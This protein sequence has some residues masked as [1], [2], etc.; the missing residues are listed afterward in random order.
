LTLYKDTSSE[1]E[2]SDEPSTLVEESDE[3]EPEETSEPNVP[4][5]PTPPPPPTAARKAAPRRKGRGSWRSSRR[6]SKKKKLPEITE[7]A[8]EEKKDEAEEEPSNNDDTMDDGDTTAKSSPVPNGDTSEIIQPE[9]KEEVTKNDLESVKS[10]PMEEEDTQVQPESNGP[11]K[12]EAKEIEGDNL[13]KGEEPQEAET[14]ASTPPTTASSQR[15]TVSQL[16]QKLS[17]ENK[18]EEEGPEEKK[19]QSDDLS[20]ELKVRADEEEKEVKPEENQVQPPPIQPEVSEK[21]PDIPDPERSSFDPFFFE[22]IVSSVEELQE[23]IERFQDTSSG[24]ARPRCEV[25]LRERLQSLLEEAQPLAADQQQANQKICQQ[26]WKEWERYK[27]LERKTAAVS[28]NGTG[29]AVCS[30]NP[31][32]TTTDSD[33]TQDSGRSDDSDD[34]GADNANDSSDD[35]T[36]DTDGVRHSKRLRKRRSYNIDGSTRSSSPGDEE[37]QPPSKQNRKTSYNYDPGW[38][39]DPSTKEPLPGSSRR[40]R[41]F[42]PEMKNP[43]YWIGRRKTRATAAF[44]GDDDNSMEFAQETRQPEEPRHDDST[45]T[46]QSLPST[47][48]MSPNSSQSSDPLVDQLRQLRRQQALL[49]SNDLP[50]ATGAPSGTTISNGSSPAVFFPSKDTQGKL[51][52]VRISNPKATDFLTKVSNQPPS[53]PKVAGSDGRLPK[54]IVISQQPQ[55]PL[56]RPMG[57][58][59]QAP[60]SIDIT[61]FVSSY[62]NIFSASFKTN[63]SLFF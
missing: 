22:L 32:L 28:A 25:K 14:G 17:T 29:N 60:F 62:S 53:T 2:D 63:Y 40:Q 41:T 16:L 26:L 15:F 3:N 5:D 44:A 19:S 31:Y 7:E 9:V 56:Q 20:E 37:M 1:S 52:S 33:H 11:V 21:V 13:V 43:E 12:E 30:T 23:W 10:E 55:P 24:R 42:D 48:Q 61:N 34:S 59:V 35:G 36:A 6:R 45:L 49:S 38:D 46:D 47:D 18:E 57:T 58:P 50:K 27:E 4:E 8:E 39:S 51:T 54:R